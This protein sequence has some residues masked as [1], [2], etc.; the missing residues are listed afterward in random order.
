[1]TG[2]AA[3]LGAAAR[4]AI[5]RHD[6]WDVPHEFLTLHW[7]GSRVVPRLVAAILLDMPAPAIPGI[8]AS[9]A[10]E[11]RDRG[12][13][14]LA[15]GYLLRIEEFG[16]TL[17]AGGFPTAAERERFQADR[18]NRTFHQRPDAVEA[19]TA[20]V[21]AP[22]GR[23]WSATHT[24]DDPSRIMESAYAPGLGRMPGGHFIVAILGVAASY[25]AAPV[26]DAS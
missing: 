2:L 19:A 11:Q 4:E 20:W 12:P 24:R 23:L 26:P 1:M 8:M 9:M 16:V 25:G 18:R 14:D 21:A 3:G 5:E 17:P 15:C 13:G 22:N 7:D 6:E 10:A